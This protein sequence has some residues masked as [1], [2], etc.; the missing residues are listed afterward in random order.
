MVLLIKKS[1]H[2]TQDQALWVMGN[3]DPPPIKKAAT[4]VA[5]F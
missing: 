2:Y 3:G 4:L 5:A 1:S